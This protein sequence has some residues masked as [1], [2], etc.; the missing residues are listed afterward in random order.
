M[1]HG[2]QSKGNSCRV[3]GDTEKYPCHFQYNI[4][5]EIVYDGERFIG[6]ICPSLFDTQMMEM[7]MG[8]YLSGPRYHHKWY[9]HPMWY[10]PG[11]V[12]DVS[13]KK[14]DGRGWKNV[15]EPRREPNYHMANLVPG[16]AWQWPIPQEKT[17]CKEPLVTCPDLRTAA[18]LKLEAVGLVDQ[19]YDIVFFRREMSVLGKI[20]KEQGVKIDKIIDLFSRDEIY[21][22]YPFLTPMLISVFV[23]E[24]EL[25]G[26]VDVR[27]GV[28]SGTGKGRAKVEDYVS[29]LSDEEEKHSTCK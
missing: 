4:G 14:Y 25:M 24:L 20:L 3:P 7:I 1:K 12:T 16:D 26:Y 28:V 21:E 17:V 10:A 8:L 22:V 2:I 29:S 13:R 5:D 18:V 23:E 11:S 6:R 15:L 19:G 27:D 9:H